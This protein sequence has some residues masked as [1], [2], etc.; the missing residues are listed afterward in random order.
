MARCVSAILRRSIPTHL[1]FLWFSTCTAR[2]LTQRR[3]CFCPAALLHFQQVGSWCYPVPSAELCLSG[4]FCGVSLLPGGGAL[5]SVLGSWLS[6]HF[7]SGFTSCAR[8]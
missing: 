6:Q 4:P 8:M 3:R 5:L 2:L 7:G 1:P